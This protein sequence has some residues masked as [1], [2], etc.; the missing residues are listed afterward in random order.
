MNIKQ[1]ITPFDKGFSKAEHRAA[2]RP[3][4]SYQRSR[5]LQKWMRDI[6]RN[7]VPQVF[8]EGEVHLC[9]ARGKWNLRALLE[10]ESVLGDFVVKYS[11]RSQSKN[12]QKQGSLVLRLLL[13]N[14]QQTYIH[15]VE[16]GGYDLSVISSD[17]NVAEQLLLSLREKFLPT[18]KAAKKKK[19][20]F[21][22]INVT[23]ENVESKRI[24]MRE[25]YQLASD[26]LNLHY[27]DQFADWEQGFIKKLGAGSQGLTILRGDPGTGKTYFIR[28]LISRLRETHIFYLINLTDFDLLTSPTM[29]EFWSEEM[30]GRDH[31]FDIKGDRKKKKKMKRVIIIEDAERLLSVR[32]KDSSGSVSELLNMCDGLLGDFLQVHLVCTANCPVD[33]FDPAVVRSGRLTAMKE[34]V[35]L[36]YTRAREIAGKIGIK[37]EEGKEYTLAEIYNQAPNGVE[38]VKASAKIGFQ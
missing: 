7:Q 36:D 18:A 12:P 14:S 9:S 4:N 28:H 10:Q 6:F 29:V 32:T 3:F 38:D 8:A 15:M 20:F 16:D 13:M 21:N 37:L 27:G 22:L 11:L 1:V 34:F 19:A 23:K 24:K 31:P 30:R 2:A 5:P 17:A 26:D 33:D 35:P 25:N